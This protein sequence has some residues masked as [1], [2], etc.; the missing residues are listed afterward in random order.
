LV[1]IGSSS[2]VSD[3]P[4]DLSHSLD[5]GYGETHLQLVPNAGDW[6]G[7]DTD[8]LPI[9]PRTRAARARTLPAGKR[10]AGEWVNYLIAFV[11]L[12]G[13]VLASWLRR[14][15]VRPLDLGVTS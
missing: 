6:A 10:G 1:V 12:G 9:R 5:S 15:S 11:G 4:L 13:V 2:F 7:Q 14:R 3:D 8:P